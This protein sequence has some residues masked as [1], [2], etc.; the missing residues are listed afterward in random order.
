MSG[1]TLRPL[2]LRQALLFAG[3]VAALI[4]AGGW[5]HANLVVPSIIN[6]VVEVT[7]RHVDRRL[8]DHSELA[9]VQ[10]STMQAQ[11]DRIERRLDQVI[12]TPPRISASP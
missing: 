6:Q 10:L 9:G 12:G 2:D 3:I 7:D 11:L 4:S 1:P 8:K 5:I